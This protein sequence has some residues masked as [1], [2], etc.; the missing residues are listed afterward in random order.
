[1]TDILGE[2]LGEGTFSVVRQAEDITTNKKW[3][4][5]VIEIAKVEAEAMEEQLKR[6]I[7]ISKKMRHPNVVMMREVFKTRNHI[8]IVLEF[9]TGGELFDRIVKSRYFP[10]SVARNFFQQLIEGIRYCHAQGV[11][12]RDLKPEN[13]LLNDEDTLK[14]MDFGLA[15]LQKDKLLQTTCGTPNYVAPEVLTE[16][17][18]DGFSADVWSCGVILYVMLAGKLPFEDKNMRGLFEKIQR[19]QYS[20]PRHF[21]EGAKNLLSK[22]LVADPKQRATIEDIML[23]E[24]FQVDYVPVAGEAVEEVSEDDEMHAIDEADAFVETVEASGAPQRMNAFDLA[25]RLMT[26]K[27]TP[28]MSGGPPIRSTT[29]FMASFSVDDCILQA[30]TFLQNEGFDVEVKEDALLIKCMRLRPRLTTFAVHIL[31]TV[32]P[33]LV[34]VDVRRGKGDRLEFNDMFRNLSSFFGHKGGG[35]R[36]SVVTS[37]SNTHPPP[38]SQR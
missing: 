36:K 5:K 11:A 26:G 8:N 33:R 34:M 24:W 15:A 19:A 1:M 27:L 25:S 23:D 37:S 38:G 4:V 29:R 31:P 22:I 6:E 20:F 12:H 14:I 16:R 21:S 17:G 3:A 10:E 18:Y 13:L 2:K 35:S 9:V 28:L 30:C 7:A 32:S